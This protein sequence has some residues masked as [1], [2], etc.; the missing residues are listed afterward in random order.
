MYPDFKSR[1]VER[2]KFKDRET[3]RTVWQLTC[4][5][6]F[7]SKHSYYDICP[8][9]HD[10]KF[11]VFSSA[12]PEGINTAYRDGFKAEDGLVCVLEIESGEIF[13]VATG[14]LY[15]C[16]VGSFALWHPKKNILYFRRSPGELG[17]V[18]VQS[19]SKESTCKAG[20]FVEPASKRGQ[21]LAVRS[22]RAAPFPLD[23]S[24]IA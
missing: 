17:I 6:E 20:G 12:R 3:G 2:L 1:G 4:S 18:D 9:S 15:I 13:T 10:G 16:H 5:Q 11:L 21:I 7:A 19:G 22:L 23:T 24:R 8:W 14:T